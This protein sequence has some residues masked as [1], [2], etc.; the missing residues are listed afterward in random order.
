MGLAKGIYNGIFHL[1]SAFCNA[2]IGLLGKYEE[3][4][5]LIY[6]SNDM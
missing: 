2:G 5:S 3:F 6:F 4:S 1:I